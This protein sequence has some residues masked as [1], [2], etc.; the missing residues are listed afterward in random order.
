MTDNDD[1]RQ[2]ERLSASFSPLSN[3]GVLLWWQRH[4]LIVGIIALAWILIPML[5]AGRSLF[6]WANLPPA[7]VLGVDVVS[8]HGRSLWQ[9]MAVRLGFA[10]RRATGQTRWTMRP[11]SMRQTVGLVDLPGAAG[12][13]M[14][15]IEVVDT[16]YEGACFLWDKES[17]QATAV[18]HL[19]GSPLLFH[20]DEEKD[21]RAEAFSKIM[22]DMAEKPDVVRVVTQAR[23]LLTPRPQNPAVPSTWVEQEADDMMDEKMTATMTHDMIVTVTVDPAKAKDAVRSLG[24]GVAGVSGLLKLRLTD[25]VDALVSGAGADAAS[26]VVWMDWWQIR[27]QM[28]QLVDPEAARVLNR[29]GELLDD[30]PVATSWSEYPKE[31]RVGDRWARTLWVDRWPHERVEIGFLDGLVAQSR[32]QMVFTQAWTVIP[33]DKADRRLDNRLAELERLQKLN[34]SLGRAPSAKVSQ[35]IGQLESRKEQ[36]V[37]NPAEVGFQGFVTLLAGSRDQLDKGQRRLAGQNKLL[38]FDKML[39][40]QWAGWV[41]AQPLGQAGR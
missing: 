29:R 9:I 22:E 35:E 21:M 28:K 2:A 10:L 27:A 30:V 13:R 20:R 23:S 41:A 14:K 26:P 31:I 16:E 25:L 6:D 38:H 11:M 24:G 8:V 12:Q 34:A 18:L 7:V 15:P 40:Q 32:M 36:L 19:M 1:S 37:S 39:G 4:Q 33:G 5:A 3:A 17:G